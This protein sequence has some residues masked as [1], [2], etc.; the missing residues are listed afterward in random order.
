MFD[1]SQN[2]I[3]KF[4]VLGLLS[5]LLVFLLLSVY[6]VRYF[7]S[8]TIID[9]WA[10]ISGEKKT[11]IHAECLNQ[12]YSYQNLV[13][14]F[15]YQLQKNKKLTSAV[16]QQNSRKAFDALFETEGLGNFN[17][18]IYNTRLE[19]LLFN[20]RQVYPEI[21]EMKRALNG[22]RFSI[23]KV[24]GIYT[25][26]IIFDPVKNESGGIEGVMVTSAIIDINPDVQ[27]RF[28]GKS[29]L[30]SD[31]FNK[32][33]I[34]VLFSFDSLSNFTSGIDTS[35]GEFSIASL[36]NINGR[37]FGKIYIPNLDQSSY[38]LNV[39]G[40]FNGVI[41]FIVFILNART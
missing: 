10:G 24:S 25:Y 37:V 30:R 23:V 36:K 3:R 22:E 9:D 21:S 34:E 2:D 17:V 32:F 38:L 31:I 41:G 18:E 19:M 26:L 13:S 28:F 11:E 12:F 20:G 33:H 7:F 16:A 4:K 14:Q 35:A 5:L 15:S 1:F 6:G 27:T 40:K 39:I 29:G 8:K